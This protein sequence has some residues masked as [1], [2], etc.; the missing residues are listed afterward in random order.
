MTLDPKILQA[1]ESMRASSK[2]H[3]DE[4]DK[5]LP[6][7]IPEVERINDLSYGPDPKWQLL[8]IYLPKKRTG[9]VPV[10]ISIHGGGWVYGTKETYQFYGLS[11]AKEG[12]AFVNFNYRLAPDV[13]FPSEM[14]DVNRLMHWV[15]DHGAEYDLDTDNV[16]LV[17][18]S[19][20][21]QMAEQ[22]LAI[23]TNPNY[24]QLFAY[25]LPNLTVRAAALNCGAYFLLSPGSRN[26][27]P[28]AYFIPEAISGKEEMLNTEKYLTPALPP[29]FIMTANRDF[30]R[31]TA[32]R[33]DGYLLAKEIP[34]ELHIYG[35][36]ENPRGHVFHCDQKDPLAK[37]CNLDE[38]DFFRKYL[39]K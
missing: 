18:D 16:F 9:K 36:S 17:G 1:V 24:R 30:L 7:D 2:A 32:I 23:L 37:Q 28:A 34:H 8:D 21:G 33:L 27:A 20:G 19:A 5:D 38:L 39:K 35:D 31:D 4:R 22:Y 10:I 26:G 13:H 15:A 14:D 12:F 3:D 6:T 11:L 29:L 25:D